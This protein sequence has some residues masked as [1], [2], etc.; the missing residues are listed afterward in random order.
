MHC[1]PCIADSADP[2]EGALG[3]VDKRSN[4]PARSH[5][6]AVTNENSPVY[7]TIA[8]RRSLS[9]EG[10]SPKGGDILLGTGELTSHQLYRGASTETSPV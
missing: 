7:L 4:A 9:L 2:S 3:A 1:L 8:I 5:A 10:M 6:T